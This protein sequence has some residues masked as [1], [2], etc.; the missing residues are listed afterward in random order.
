MVAGDYRG[1]NSFVGNGRI[2]GLNGRFG[3]VNGGENYRL[4][5]GPGEKNLGRGGA[6]R[7]RRAK[8]GSGD[9]ERRA[10]KGKADFVRH[11]PDFAPI[12]QMGVLAV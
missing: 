2:W 6:A 9:D 7:V 11:V 4:K 5:V 12:S 3:G 10:G 8:V 1:V